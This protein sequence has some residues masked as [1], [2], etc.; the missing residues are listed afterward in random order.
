MSDP[1]VMVALRDVESTD[2]LIQLACQLSKG[3]ECEVV[4]LHVVEVTPSLPLD[5]EAEV[6]DQPGKEILTRARETAAKCFSTAITA[7][8]V[9]ARDAGEAIVGEAL[10]GHIDLLVMGH[11]RKSPLG[12]IFLGSTAQHVARHAS[13][14]VIIQIPEAG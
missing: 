13:C 10:D 9:R 12:E 1:K 2:S 6:L 8:L 5:A 11:R 7:R 14:R 3:M 4:A